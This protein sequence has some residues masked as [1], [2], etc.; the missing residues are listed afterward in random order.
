LYTM[1]SHH[2]NQTPSP[3]D[4]LGLSGRQGAWHSLRCQAPLIRALLANHLCATLGAG[5]LIAWLSCL[6]RHFV[7]ATR[8]DTVAAW[9]SRFG[10]PHATRP[11]T[12]TASG[13]AATASTSSTS[14]VIHLLLSFA[15]R[16]SPF[17]RLLSNP[18]E[19]N[20][21]P[22][23]LQPDG[24]QAL[25]DRSPELADLVPKSEKAFLSFF[26]PQ[27]GHSTLGAEEMERTSFSNSSPHS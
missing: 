20:Y 2:L 24:A 6:V 10:T 18:M 17:A 16:Y 23:M 27:R 13:T 19:V 25:A 8:A 14:H 4:A 9:S 21:L 3:S 15:M 7:A 11:A 5:H 26:P 12:A 22:E 1:S